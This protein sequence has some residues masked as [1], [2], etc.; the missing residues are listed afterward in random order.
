MLGQLTILDR[1]HELVIGNDGVEILVTMILFSH[2]G[3]AA[4]CS[5]PQMIR[6]HHI[7]VLNCGWDPGTEI[8]SRFLI[9]RA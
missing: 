2:V 9:G 6:H 7:A 8:V 1:T 5:G 3:S 4:T